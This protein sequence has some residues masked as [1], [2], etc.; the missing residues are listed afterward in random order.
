MIGS[1]GREVSVLG[2]VVTEAPT[3]RWYLS[4]DTKGEGCSHE[5]EGEDYF[6][7]KD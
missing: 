4:L 7:Q 5:D 3:E 2:P 6:R 1:V